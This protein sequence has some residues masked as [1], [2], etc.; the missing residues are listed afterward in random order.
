[1]I[2]LCFVSS[3]T[4]TRIQLNFHS[5]L[6]YIHA[7]CLKQIINNTSTSVQNEILIGMTMLKPSV[8]QLH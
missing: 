2:F 8:H 4:T 1:M 5:N 6:L 3:S 7:S